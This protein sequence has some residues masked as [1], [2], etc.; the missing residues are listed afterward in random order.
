LVR[1][2]EESEVLPAAVLAV[3]LRLWSH[4][5]ELYRYGVICYG[6]HGSLTAFMEAVLAVAAKLLV[7][8]S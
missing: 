4:Q 1:K 6:V 5:R 7:A 8:G 2:S 3:V